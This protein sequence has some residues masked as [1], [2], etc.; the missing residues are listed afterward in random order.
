MAIP[1][2]DIEITGIRSAVARTIGAIDPLEGHAK[3]YT[4]ALY[5]AGYSSGSDRVKQALAGFGEH[6]RYTLP[7]VVVRTSNCIRAVTTATNAYLRADEEM[8]ERAQRNAQKAPRVAD[9]RMP[10]K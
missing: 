6:H 4:D 10:R 2:W 9:L 3:T 1:G 8:A 5:D 7:L